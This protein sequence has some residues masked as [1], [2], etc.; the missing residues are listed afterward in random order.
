ME[1][2]AMTNRSTVSSIDEYIA[3]FP[4]ETQ[5]VLEELR[6]LVRA[7]APGVTERISYAI[8]TFELNGRYLVYFGGWKKHVGFY[9]VTSGVAEAFKEELKPYKSGKG[10]VQFPLGRPMPL[11]LIRR[12]VEFRVKEIMGSD[13]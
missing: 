7:T 6:S 11:D 5:K 3:E 10:S 4:P 13:I 1:R 9:P 12:I 2:H 8:P